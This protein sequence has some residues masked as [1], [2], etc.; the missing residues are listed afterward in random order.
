MDDE[1]I[2]EFIAKISEQMFILQKNQL[3]LKSAVTVLKG[4]AV[5][6]MNPSDPLE[7]AK[8]LRNLEK[9]LLNSEPKHQELEEVLEIIEALKVAK[10]HGVGGIHEA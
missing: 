7:G 2:N 10:D 3:E 4:L 8:Q 9:T 6:E 1:T 5:L